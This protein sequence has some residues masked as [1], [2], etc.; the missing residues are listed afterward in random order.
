MSVSCSTKL[1]NI[2]LLLPRNAR[3]LHSFMRKFS[4]LLIDEMQHFNS[5][6]YA[7]SFKSISSSVWAVL[8]PCA[9]SVILHKHTH[10]HQ[11]HRSQY[12]WS[13]FHVAFVIL[14]LVKITLKCIRW[15]R[16][17]L[18]TVNKTAAFVK[19]TRNCHSLYYDFN[20]KPNE[21][22]SCIA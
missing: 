4:T 18:I 10:T 14:F 12:N 3:Q 17:L 8:F 21:I 15:A 19:K 5:I 11:M 9:I 2:F 20:L 13:D 7:H 16:V 22:Y 1:T 6:F